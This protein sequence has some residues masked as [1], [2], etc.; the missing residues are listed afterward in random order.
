MNIKVCGVTNL[1]QLNQLDKMGVDY[2]GLVFDPDSCYYA[3]DKISPRDLNET[4]LY[5]RKIGV[6]SNT[7][8]DQVLSI[9]EKYNLDI[10]QLCGEETPE[11]CSVI[12]SQ[13]ELIKTFFP[14]DF[15]ASALND[16][17]S[18]YD[19][20]CD[21]YSF[22]LMPSQK[23]NELSF[24]HYWKAI[25]EASFEKPFFMGGGMVRPTDA[26]ILHTFKHPDFFGVEVNQYFERIPGIKD[27]SLILSF[28]RAINQ[29]DN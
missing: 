10:I 7:N 2:A 5:I 16:L 25:I 3:A 18:A 6:F 20:V 9:A 26:P 15:N 21:F 29:V 24:A 1:K 27:T 22:D 11:F 28:M 14:S 4:E 8:I 17:V 23:N 12:S 19:E 13:L